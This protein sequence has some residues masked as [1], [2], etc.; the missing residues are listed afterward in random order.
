MSISAANINRL[1]AKVETVMAG[2][3]ENRF[4]CLSAFL[5][6]ASILYGGVT[7]IRTECFRKGLFIT[8]RLPCKVISVGNITVGGTGKTP[9][10]I[11]VARL[12][13]KLGRSPAI[14]SRGYKGGAESAGGVVSDG[15]AIL[16]GP[17]A[18]GDEPYLMAS[19]LPNIPV[20][21][22]KDRFTAGERAIREFHPD[23]IVLD[24]AFQH[25]RL[26]RDV[27][28]ALLDHRRP[29]GNARL[30]PRGPLREPLSALSRADAYLIT[31]A[32]APPSSASLSSANTPE[33]PDAL[34]RN[35]P[36]FYTTHAPYARQASK[37]WKAPLYE[38]LRE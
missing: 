30:L 36:V 11:Y 8:K 18:S 17:D 3:G 19:A 22:G 5:S 15:R 14:I 21:V 4:P 29:F 34:N 16:L 27:N 33:Q 37:G 10:A 25:L 23:V 13:Q 9:M 32:D 38:L 12:L 1:K 28:L 7:K 26:S 31:R 24:D 6:L 35:T 2:E 20:L